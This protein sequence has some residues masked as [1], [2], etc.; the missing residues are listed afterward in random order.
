MIQLHC[1]NGEVI[2]HLEQEFLATGRVHPTD[3]PDAAPAW[4]EGDAVN[5]AITLARVSGCPTYVVHLSTGVGLEAIGR[6]QA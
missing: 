4:V 1:E 6:A 3:F 5:R 2:D